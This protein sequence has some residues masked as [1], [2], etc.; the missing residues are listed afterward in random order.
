M[1]VTLARQGPATIGGGFG[2]SQDLSDLRDCENT[3][4]QQSKQSL[5]SSPFLSTRFYPKKVQTRG[6]P[7][8]PNLQGVTRNCMNHPSQREHQ[9]SRKQLRWR[10]WCP[11]WRTT[12]PS[13]SGWGHNQVI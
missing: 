8:A 11:L 9:S 7:A 1:H 6:T 2:E 12:R 10:C 4:G 3:T 5:F 13:G